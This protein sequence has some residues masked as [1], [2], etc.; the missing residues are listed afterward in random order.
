MRRKERKISGGRTHFSQ[1]ILQI[2]LCLILLLCVEEVKTPQE[3]VMF[4]LRNRQVFQ[5]FSRQT[6]Y[7]FCLKEKSY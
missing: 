6:F 5:K 2:A 7:L 1:F 4:L 3:T